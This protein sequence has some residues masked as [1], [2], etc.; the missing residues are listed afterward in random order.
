MERAQLRRG[1]VALVALIALI[2]LAVV[3]MDS[4]S[5]AD[6]GTG[7]KNCEPGDTRP[8]CNPEDCPGSQETNC[9]TNP[10]QKT[11][12]CN[13]SSADKNPHCAPLGGDD[14]DTG[15]DD[16]GGGDDDDVSDGDGVT[17]TPAQ[18]AVAAPPQ[19]AETQVAA[20]GQAPAGQAPAGAAPDVG[21]GDSGLESASGVSTVQVA[22]V[23]LLAALT[24]PAMLVA[25][26]RIN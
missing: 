13:A 26:R 2:T 19:T 8:V 12:G 3:S 4:R 16:D 5:T 17:T 25:A 20:A 10:R 6:A 21:T 7:P 18:P 22:L 23:G 11:A 1:A 9:G 24:V 15:D 14:D